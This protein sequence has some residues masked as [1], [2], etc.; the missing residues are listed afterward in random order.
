[1]I[2]QKGKIEAGRQVK[3]LRVKSDEI[4]KRTVRKGKTRRKTK[5]KKEWETHKAKSGKQARHEGERECTF[6]SF[7]GQKTASP[8]PRYKSEL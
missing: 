4:G 7:T 6:Q 2:G 3:R 1:M 5:T 8:R